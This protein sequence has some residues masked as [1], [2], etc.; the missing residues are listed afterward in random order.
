MTRWMIALA[1][2][3]GIVAARTD[4]FAHTCESSCGLEQQACRIEARFERITSLAGCAQSRSECSGSCDGDRGACR[5]TCEAGVL[6]CRSSCSSGDDILS[7]GAACEADH[8]L[9]SDA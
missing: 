3:L 8:D 5:A 9:C 4:A 6:Q 2:A 7:C 1:V